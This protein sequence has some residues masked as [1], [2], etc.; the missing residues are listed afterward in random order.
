LSATLKDIERA[1]GATAPTPN[2]PPPEADAKFASVSLLIVISN[3]GYVCSAQVIRGFDKETDARAMQ[4]VRHWR[5]HPSTK[6]TESWF[7][8]HPTNPRNES[9]PEVSIQVLMELQ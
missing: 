6:K 2:G 5:F 9:K 7:L 4:E 3:R 8:P 1:W